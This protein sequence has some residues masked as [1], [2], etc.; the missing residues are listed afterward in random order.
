MGT[1]SA[2]GI[3]AAEIDGVRG[4]G[5]AN[6]AG[7]VA[8]GG[9]GNGGGGATGVGGGA[10]G[11]TLTGAVVEAASL[12]GPVAQAAKTKVETHKAKPNFNVILFV[13]PLTANLDYANQSRA[14]TSISHPRHVTHLHLQ[15]DQPRR[16]RQCGRFYHQ[17]RHRRW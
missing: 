17:V 10:G 13:P 9:G 6:G 5:G 8:T 1:M 11:V 2:G 15:Q 16:P 4:G 12:V 3:G 7:G 14:Q